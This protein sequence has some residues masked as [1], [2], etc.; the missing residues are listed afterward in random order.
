MRTAADR[1]DRLTESPRHRSWLL[2]LG[3]SLV[4]LAFAVQGT[5]WRSFLGLLTEGAYALLVP[6][7]LLQLTGIALRAEGW[8]SLLGPSVRFG[9]VFAAIN[10]GYLLNNLLPFRLGEL[11]RA[12]LV[13]RASGIGASRSLGSIAVERLTDLAIAVLSL[14]VAFALHAPPIWASRT[15]IMASA[16]VVVGVGGVWL[17]LARRDVV[18]GRLRR[19]PGRLASRVAGMLERFVSGLDEARQGGRVPRALAW[20]LLGWA[21]AWIQFELYL[22]LFG[23]TGS[24]VVSLFGLAAIALGGAVPSS[25]GAIGVYELAGVTALTFLGY[26]REVALGVSLAGHAV[27]YSLTV[28]LGS[29]AL[30]REGRSIGDLARAARRL[31]ARPVD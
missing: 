22:R 6:A 14:L 21:C 20:L 4:A 3:V 10:E 11:G 13:G 9:T 19:L 23:A 17:V 5:D 28:V 18:L 2:G 15:A 7:Y 25:P 29:I 27:Q 16:V 24:I 1:P 31:V 8:R 12:Y 26:T 30:S